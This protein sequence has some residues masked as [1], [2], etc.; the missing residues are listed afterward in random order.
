MFGT[1]A[2]QNC[3]KISL[4]LR[5]P[6]EALFWVHFE[7]RNCEGTKRLSTHQLMLYQL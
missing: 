3:N 5:K 2:E 7:T 1:Q 6:M 4:G